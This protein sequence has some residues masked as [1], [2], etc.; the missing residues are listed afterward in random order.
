[1]ADAKA[2]RAAKFGVMTVDDAARAYVAL[3]C[4]PPNGGG[5]HVH[6][7]FGAS[8]VMAYDM[9]Q[10]FGLVETDGALRKA[11]AEAGRAG[12]FVSVFAPRG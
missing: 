5:R 8:Y 6:S 10:H 12:A 7:V 2:A 11:L 4:S 1:M 9:I 3:I